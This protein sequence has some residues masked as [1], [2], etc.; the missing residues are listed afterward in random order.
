[1]QL[2]TFFAVICGLYYF[3][4]CA[5]SWS[6]AWVFMQYV[7]LCGYRLF[8]GW[9]NLQTCFDLIYISVTSFLTILNPP[10]PSQNPKSCPNHSD[11]RYLCH[12]IIIR[13]IWPHYLIWDSEGEKSSFLTSWVPLQPL[14]T[15]LIWVMI[16]YFFGS[17]KHKSNQIEIQRFKSS[18]PRNV[19]D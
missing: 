10:P 17:D 1:M 11:L 15:M 4:L 5:S 2:L 13:Y 6:E 19:S 7:R 12:F 9:V 3:R 8:V 16:N 18:I 14:S